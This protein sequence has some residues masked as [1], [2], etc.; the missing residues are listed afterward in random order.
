[1]PYFTCLVYT[2]LVSLK[3]RHKRNQESAGNVS[4]GYAHKHIRK[5][6]QHNNVGNRKNHCFC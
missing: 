2:L 4:I 6:A 3:Y 1:M 5:H